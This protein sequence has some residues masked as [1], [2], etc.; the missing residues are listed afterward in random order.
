[1]PSFS[2]CFPLAFQ[3]AF[4]QWSLSRWFSRCPSLPLSLFQ[5]RRGHELLLERFGL[6]GKAM[7]LSATVDW[8]NWVSTTGEEQELEVSSEEAREEFRACVA[9]LNYLGQESP[10]VQFLVKVLSSEMARPMTGSWRRLKKVVLF[11]VG[12]RRVVWQFPWQSVE[13]STELK[14]I[15]D[16]DCGGDN[17]SRKSTSGGAAMRGKH[18]LKTWST[19]QGA[20]ALS[21][22]EAELYAM[23]DGVLRTNAMK[24]MLLE[25]GLANTD[26]VI[27]FQIDSAAGNSFIS[28]RGLGKMRHMELRDFWIQQEVGG[29]KVRAVK[30][31]GKTNP[32]DVETKF[33]SATELAE[34]DLDLQFESC[35]HQQPD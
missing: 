21:T 5:G 23:V 30:I 35:A 18:C 1:M 13:E 10:D 29:G 11:L 14:V 33:L 2:C 24:S 27:E 22:A 19:T 25:T 31:G 20:T 8:V 4:A 34:L 16:A 9:R 28:R 17:R 15:T 26:D 7:A 12:R 6:D 32:A 3:E